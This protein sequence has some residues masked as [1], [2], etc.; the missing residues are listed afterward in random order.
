MILLSRFQKQIHADESFQHLYKVLVFCNDAEKLDAK[1]KGDPLDIS[2]L[3]FAD[4]FGEGKAE[5][6]RKNQRVHE[7][8]F[9]SDSKF[10][11]AVHKLDGQLYISG[12]G[13]VEQILSRSEFYFEHGERRKISD[14]I[15]NKWLKRNDELS[16][17]GLKVIACAY[18]TAEE[19]KRE[20]L[21]EQ[22]DFI[23]QMIF[24][25]LV[26][27]IDPAKKDV[28]QAIEK[29]RRAGIKVIMITGD[30]SGTAQNIAEKVNLQQAEE[31]EVMEGEEIEDNAEDIY[32]A[33]LFA[34]VD[35][36]QKH[37]IVDHFKEKG[38]ITAMTGDGVNDAPAL[39]RADIGIAMG[40]RGTQLAREVADMVLKDDSFPSIVEA[41]EEGR[42]IFGNIRKF[43][44]YQLSYHLAEIIIIAGIS[45]T[46]FYIPLLPLQLLFLNLLSDVFPALALGLGKGNKNV[47]KQKPKDPREPII[48]KRNWIT[49]AVYGLI[50]AVIVTGAYLITLFYFDQSKETANTIAFLASLFHNCFTFLI[51]ANLK[52][53]FSKTR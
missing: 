18:R 15:K 16:G 30:H 22:D 42:I 43:I 51:C 35:P 52:N 7:D 50:I 48:N 27:F 11:G 29:C 37:E 32:E 23:H 20:K 41:I 38:E 45:F 10:M 3:E 44:V 34:R 8:P 4:K 19:G 24:I 26:C 31:I 39:K 1:I 40:K 28:S 53:T 36:K 49:T 14:D 5:D 33:N 12:K 13:A 46:L 17:K 2:L 9:D 47:M 21:K 6:L 25:G